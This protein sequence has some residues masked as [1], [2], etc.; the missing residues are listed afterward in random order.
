MLAGS[1][2][3]EMDGRRLRVLAVVDDFTHEYLCLVADTSLS[4]APLARELD[5]LVT[6]RAKPKTIVSDNCTEMTSMASLKWCQR[7]DIE[8]H[9]I[10]HDKPMQNGFVECFNGSF[11]DKCLNETLFASLPQA[12][13]ARSTWKEGYSR[14]RPRFLLDNITLNEFTMKMMLEKLAA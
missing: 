1:V 13:A 11:H 9:Y 2:V 7:T 5:S 4:G 14:S 12:R 10:A 6:R 8:W 3:K